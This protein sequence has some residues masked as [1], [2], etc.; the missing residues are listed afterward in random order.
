M[1]G[2]G[3]GLVAGFG[4]FFALLTIALVYAD[5]RSRGQAPSCAL[6]LVRCNA[7]CRCKR[8]VHARPGDPSFRQQLQWPLTLHAVGSSCIT[9]PP[10]AQAGATTTAKTSTPLG[11]P[12]RPASSLW[13]SS[14]TGEGPA[15]CLCLVSPPQEHA[16]IKYGLFFCRTWSSTLL[17][18]SNEV[19]T[20]GISGAFW[21][22]P[23][24]RLLRLH[25]RPHG[26]WGDSTD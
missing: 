20:Y 24:H 4:A 21:W 2:A 9:C 14:P 3:Y 11:A 10:A 16:N 6:H 18:S 25:T 19:F 15:S 26:C 5:Y 12:S 17:Q 22:G 7:A 1:Q 23:C 13:T 8:Y